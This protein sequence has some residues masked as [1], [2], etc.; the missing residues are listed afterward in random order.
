MSIE[1][2]V[3]C[4]ECGSQRNWKDGYRYTKYGVVQRYSCRDCGYRFSKY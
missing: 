4:P 3:K 1:Q 2:K